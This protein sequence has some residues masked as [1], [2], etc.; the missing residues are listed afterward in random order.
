MA[1]RAQLLALIDQ[2][3][4]DPSSAS[5][6]LEQA[7]LWIDQ[8]L[9]TSRLPPDGYMY[10]G[11]HTLVASWDEL[12]VE[13]LPDPSDSASQ[14]LTATNNPPYPLKVPFDA[15]IQGVSG[16]AI[17]KLPSGL[18]L[19][20]LNGILEMG[21]CMDG[22]DLFAVMWNTDGKID[23]GTDGRHKLLEPAPAVL[24]TRR[25]PRPLGWKVRRGTRLNVY[26]RNLTNLF[27]PSGFNE[28]F[29]PGWTISVAV[30]FH[31]LNRETP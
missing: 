13:E 16:W 2:A 17:P 8:E 19:E 23:Y 30:E 31:L 24:G 4:R 21:A 11:A 29:A 18:D 26:A 28:G 27:N 22:R 15:L 20:S 9:E 25:R 6:L 10:A 12:G 14:Q 3:A 5:R 1:S 7:R